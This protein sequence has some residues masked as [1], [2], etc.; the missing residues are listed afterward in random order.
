MAETTTAR[1]PPRRSFHPTWALGV[2]TTSFRSGSRP[3]AWT[4]TSGFPA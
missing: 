1:R 2:P 3:A 4:F